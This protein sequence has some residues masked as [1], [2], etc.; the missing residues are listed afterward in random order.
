M[1]E[2]F[3]VYQRHALSPLLRWG[4]GSSLAGALLAVMPSDYWRQFGVQAA[5]WGAIDA[6]LAMAGRRDALLKAERS[7]AGDISEAQERAAAEG[8][9][10]ILLVNAGLDVLYIA[11]GLATAARNAERPGRRGL[12]H[13]IAAQG[14]FLLVFDGLLARDVGARWL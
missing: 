3:F 14:L 8:F 12:G 4:V 6:A 1:D 9:R 13:G 2:N 7:F 5:T 10:R 11:A